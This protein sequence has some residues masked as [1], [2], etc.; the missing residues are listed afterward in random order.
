MGIQMWEPPAQ[1]RLL[2]LPKPGRSPGRWDLMEEGKAHV[3]AAPRQGPWGQASRQALSSLLKDEGTE[4]RKGSVRSETNGAVPGLE[5]RL[6]RGC[7]RACLRPAA[8]AAISAHGP[9]CAPALP[10]PAN[11]SVTSGLRCARRRPSPG[12]GSVPAGALRRRHRRAPPPPRL[13]PPPPS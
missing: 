5:P 12:P 3:L 6:D 1:L 10:P 2:V 7:R 13:P 8:P 9:S 11:P 4:A